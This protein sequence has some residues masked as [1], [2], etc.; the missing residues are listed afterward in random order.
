MFDACR[1]SPIGL[2]KLPTRDPR[3]ISGGLIL[4]RS[5]SIIR[6]TL[7]I[8]LE[9]LS[10]GLKLET[11]IAEMLRIEE[12]EKIHHVHIWSL[13]PHIQAMNCPVGIACLPFR[14]RPRAKHPL[15]QNRFR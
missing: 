1:R 11:E 6:E 8:L 5:V 4:W 14:R 12:V 2:S 7:D 10:C 15:S 9:G 13:G 3:V